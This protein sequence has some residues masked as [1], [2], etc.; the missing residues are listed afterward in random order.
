MLQSLKG[1]RFCP[2]GSPTLPRYSSPLFADD[3][4]APKMLYFGLS[5]DV[6]PPGHWLPSPM[7]TALD[8][9]VSPL[10]QTL[11][12][13]LQVPDT[14]PEPEPDP[15]PE[16]EAEPV[17]AGGLEAG[18]LG[19]VEPPADPAPASGE[20]AGAELAG[21]GL[22]GAGFAGAGLDEDWLLGSHLPPAQIDAQSRFWKV[23]GAYRAGSLKS[24]RFW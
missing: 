10:V 3:V 9:L 6:Q 13:S 21:A 18:V 22:A 15:E 2:Y 20:L 17:D 19:V 7:Y 1:S 11:L 23:P 12:R 8:R 16:L 24:V 5:A 14:D 4:A